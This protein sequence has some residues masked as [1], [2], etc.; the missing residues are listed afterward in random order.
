MRTSN[1]NDVL[2]VYVQH[3]C[4]ESHTNINNIGILHHVKCIS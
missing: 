1:I 4:T 2:I 3:Y